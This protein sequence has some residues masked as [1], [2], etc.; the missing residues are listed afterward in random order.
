MSATTIQVRDG[1]AVVKTYQA[2]S[3]GSGSLVG[4]FVPLD[5]SGVYTAGRAQPAELIKTYLLNGATENM[6]VDGGTPVTYKYTVPGSKIFLLNRMIIY[7]ESAAAFSS[8]KFGSLTALSNGVTVNM[9]GTTVE[10]WKDNIDITTCMFDTPGRPNYAKDTKSLTGR[11]T[12]YKDAAGRPIELVATETVSVV[13]NDN[14]SALAYFKAKIGG[15]LI[16][17]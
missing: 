3:D 2:F 6:A 5:S 15:W 4:G 8:E 10:T 9:G 17:A 1:N 7:L 13:I 12:F 16:D 11:W 14:I